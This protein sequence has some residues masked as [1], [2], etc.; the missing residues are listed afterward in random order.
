MPSGRL[1]ATELAIGPVE[2]GP[3]LLDVAALDRGAR[4]DPEARG[5][6]AM[7][8]DVVG[9]ALLFEQTREF[10]DE[11]YLCLACQSGEIGIS[12]GKADRGAGA[13]ALAGG[14]EAD[15]RRLGD[16]GGDDCGVVLGTADERGKP[17]DL[18]GPAQPVDCVLDAQHRRGID[19]LALENRLVELALAGQAEELGQRPGRRVTFEAGDRAWAQH[20]HAM[21]SL[22]AKHLLP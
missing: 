10:L 8:G 19:R 20:Q 4:P 15:P 3:Q 1:R 12:E 16:P 13:D 9:D 14:E 6:V 7:P 5:S 21:R 17:A 2:P 11:I 18:L 22:A